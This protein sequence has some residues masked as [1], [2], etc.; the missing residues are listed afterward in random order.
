M[1]SPLSLAS[2]EEV[3]RPLAFLGRPGRS[4]E[5]V[6]AFDWESSSLGDPHL[7]PQS[8]KTAVGIVLGDGQ[9][10]TL[11]W[12]PEFITFYNDAYRPLMG[13]AIADGIGL[14]Y[15]VFRADV[16][17][18]VEKQIMAGFAGEASTVENIKV[19][20]RRHGD[21]EE[22]YFTLN[23]S[24]VYDETGSVGGVISH[25]F[26]TTRTVLAHRALA[27]E[28][29][30][31][32]RGLDHLPQMVWST[33]PDGY[34]DFYNEPW[35]AFTGVPPGSTDGE[36]WN[37]MFH[38]DDQER[39]WATW[40]HSL[41][42]GDP[43]EIR[44]RLKHK[45]GGYRWTLGRA[46]PERDEAGKIIRWYGTCTDIHEHLLAQEKLQSLQAELI[47]LS[48]VSAMGA[49]ASTLAHELN[50]PLTAIKNYATG[51]ERMV[52]RD[53][54]ISELSR[55]VAEIGKNAARAG[56]IIR[57]LREMTQ[58]REITKEPFIPDGVI[59]EAGAL[60]SVGA[61]AGLDLQ[62]DFRDGQ[63][64]MGDPI[65]IQQVMINLIRNACDAVVGGRDQ[66]VRIVSRIVGAETLISVED[67]GPGI[68]PDALPTVFDAFFT[69]K[70][71]GMGVGLSI[72]RTIVEA[73][74]GRIWAENRPE[75]GARFSFTLPLAEPVTG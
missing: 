22:A 59:R 46:L 35:Y 51:S 4:S 33:L 57:R 2:A 73:H 19:L 43:Y 13:T 47:H 69:T 55:P 58:K 49:M 31:L 45:S 68:P 71:D 40:R 62:Y 3:D 56:E 50:Q 67:S 60:A 41:R 39:A 29:S 7:W 1:P 54:K 12:G 48:R 6:K 27:D 42:T 36:G 16:W 21:A 37:D 72:S 10:C 28:N 20:S 30:Q 5:L 44:Y 34:H 64:V 66:N 32:R 70:E 38:P 75:G 63:P 23:Y 65:Q 14:P 24:P 25:V 8:L 11:I 74:R 26:E 18:S 53:A 17:P 52:E 15:P 9:A 61:C